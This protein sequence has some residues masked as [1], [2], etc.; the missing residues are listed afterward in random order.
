[1]IRWIQNLGS[2]LLRHPRLAALTLV[3]GA[4]AT[5]AGSAVLWAQY[6][7]RVARQALERYAFDEAQHHLDLCLQVR[8]GSAAVR[9]L[10]AQTA[11]RRDACDEAERHLAACV[12]LEGMTPETAREQLLLTAQQGDLDDMAGLL[13]PKTGADDPETVLV[14]EALAKGYLNRAAPLDAVE[15]L[16]RLLECQPRHPQAWLLRA[17]AWEGLDRNGKAE[18]EPDA[19]RDYEK[20]VELAPSFE[21]RRGLAGSL[22]R[23]G[24][25]WDAFRE[26]QR[27][28]R[29]QADDPEILLGLARC[30]YSLAEVDEARH[31]LDDLLRQHPDHAG[32]LL[33]R[34]RLLLHA[35]EAAEAE[36]SLRQ[37]AATSPPGDREARL[38][39]YRC[40][41]LEHK[42]AEARRCLDLLRAN[43][44]NVLEGDRLIRQAN[45]APRDTAL[46]CTIALQLL[47]LGREQDGLSGLFL[48]LDQDPRY[49]PAHAALADYFERTGQPAR[50]A[51]HRRSISD[52]RG[53]PV[54]EDREWKAG[55]G[56]AAAQLEPRGPEILGDRRPMSRTASAEQ[57]HRFCGT[58]CHA[59]PPPDVFP[60][61]VWRRE[62]KQAYD[63][64]RN[65]TLPIDFPSQES[66]ALYYE[67]HA[68][69]ELPSVQ[70]GPP[71]PPLPGSFR[72]HDYPL[73]EKQT[74]PGV[75]NVN[76]V[77][78]F[79]ARRLDVLVC[80]MTG[81]QVLALQPYTAEP[82][83]RVLYRRGPDQGFHPAHAEVVDLD[84]DGIP[85][86]LVANLGNF[87]PTDARC[88]SVVWLRGLG[89]GRFEPHTLLD[90]V[91]RVADVQAA[92]FR[93]T[94]KKDL[95]VAV[96]GWRNTGEVLYL[97]DRTTDWT[98]P[99]FVP[100][101][102]DDRH[103]AIHVPVG[104]ID[105]DGKPDIVALISQEHETI[106]AFLNQGDGNFQ[107]QTIYTAPHP[108]YGSSG[109]QLVD[110]NGDGKLDVLYTNGDSMD[111]PYLLKPYHGVQWLENR[112][113]FPFVHHPLTAMYGVMRAVAADLTG[114][115]RKDIVSVSFLPPDVF[116]QRR[117]LQLDAVVLLEQT[118]PGEFVRH[119]LET[120]TCDHFTCAAGDIYG[121][122]TVRLVTGSAGVSAADRSNPAVS[123]WE[124]VAAGRPK[125]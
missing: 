84:G 31:L 110:L 60:R 117:E 19:L 88:G 10:A 25:P 26:Y 53:S 98:K 74:V 11:R 115:G 1:V 83:W 30:Q 102:L 57:V 40:L 65:S 114:K 87:S 121:D 100:R 21:A 75:S 59:Y 58:A 76:L 15:C 12:Q 6:H 111:P 50:A 91:G 43:E 7:L 101:V 112:G 67:Q 97:E 108:A 56:P 104:D 4:L 92:D 45:A 73:P 54:S 107:K 34:G 33:E 116:P 85:D 79:D 118:R 82:T 113:V 36:M 24:R 41:E 16:N 61:S 22:Y 89:D 77:H 120:V 80:D 72:R 93:G 35:G 71:V 86:V 2:V 103:G 95:V 14:L 70:P 8:F 29:V 9:R 46:R 105:G 68:P 66:V 27:L 96:F 49:G 109:I 51:R 125:N 52:L 122:G 64:L 124:K 94:G 99:A 39:L 90:G 62:V 123:I 13:R 37:A 106:V 18:H 47:R 119:A 69:A 44:A 63:F 55:R 38:V 17:R 3:L 23:V 48:V 5:G 81:G 78:L 32:A 20:A 28:R 42:D